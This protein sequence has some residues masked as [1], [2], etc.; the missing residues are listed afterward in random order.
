MEPRSP[1]PPRH[2]RSAKILG[3]RI[4]DLRFEHGLTQRQLADATGI[5]ERYLRDL[6]QGLNTVAVRRIFQV[7]RE[8]DVHLEIVD[9]R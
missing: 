7:L 6:E 5:D 4:T 9:G 8:L 2:V 1:Q 3:E